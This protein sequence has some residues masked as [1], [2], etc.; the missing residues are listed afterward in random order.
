MPPFGPCS[1][2]YAAPLQ[3]EEDLLQSSPL[4]FI[5]DQHTVS[6][7]KTVAIY[8]VGLIGGSIGMAVRQRGLAD[9]VTGI[10]RTP[11]RLATAVELGAIDDFVT[12]VRDADDPDLVLLCTPVQRLAG[13]CAA[14]YERF[15][16]A[17]ISDAGST[18]QN[19]VEQ[20]ESSTPSANFIGSHPLAG[21]D[22]TGVTNADADLF[23]GRTVIVTPTA[24][25]D[26]PSTERLMDFWKSL[27]AHSVSMPPDRHDE[28][29]AMT[30][31]LPHVVASALAAETPAELLHLVAGGWIDSTRIAGADVDLWT[32]I[33]QENKSNVLGSLK[34]M[35]SRLQEFELALSDDD[36]ETIERLLAAGKQRRDALGS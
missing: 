7:W 15:P 22:R 6:R 12:D 23:V 2:G 3:T 20:I 9:C 27:G 28:A 4:L 19:L 33:L 30:S 25:S 35:Q 31:H 17:L 29:L 36:T 5:K 14:V 16:S 24:K 26:R 21:S 1:R 10:G 34:R 32:Q 18:K 11:E 8:G 13:H